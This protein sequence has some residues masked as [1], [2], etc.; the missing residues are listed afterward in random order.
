VNTN[1]LRRIAALEAKRPARPDSIAAESP[2]MDLQEL[3]SRLAL[4]GY[5]TWRHE[6]LTLEE[7]LA[8][9]KDDATRPPPAFWATTEKDA[10]REVECGIANAKVAAREI[11]IRIGLRDGLIDKQASNELREHLHTDPLPELP[12]V[13]R[14]DDAV[15]AS[16]RAKCPRPDDLPVETQLAMVEED[17]QR[18]L[19]ERPQREAARQEAM[20][21]NG[22]RVDM[23]SMDD[24]GDIVYKQ[25]IQKLR[26]RL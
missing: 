23:G 3:D 9:A 16:A 22:D 19:R 2:Q 11:E 26:A 7:L 18:D 15:L 10:A 21:R 13:V 8:V 20:R 6:S 4:I 12:Y 5:R 17:H 14:I 24:L 25:Q 1:L